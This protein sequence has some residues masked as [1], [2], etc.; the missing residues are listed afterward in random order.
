M[1]L[2]KDCFNAAVFIFISLLTAVL[3]YPFLHESGHSIAAVLLKAKVAEFQ[4]LPVPYIL[5]DVSQIGNL[6]RS[7]IGMAGNFV[8]MIISILVPSNCF[9]V[10]SFRC[11]L[12]GISVLA[13]GISLVSVCFLINE[14][15][16]FYQVVSYWNY[17]KM[18]LLVIALIGL[19][20]AVISLF[21]EHPVKWLRSSFDI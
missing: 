2:K 4:L 5:C 17:G 16:D 21:Y 20:L 18:S 19:I 9:A 11:T 6:G 12:K 7:I 10:K 3:I 8:P 14:Q 13:M 1:N 15:D